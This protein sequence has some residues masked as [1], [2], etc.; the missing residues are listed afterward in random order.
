ME[1]EI[2]A[3]T[4][5]HH[6]SVI[7]SEHPWE[8]PESLKNGFADIV[9]KH[10]NLPTFLMAIECKRMKTDDARQLKW[11]FLVPEG[12]EQ[13]TKR[14]SCFGV[15][16]GFKE[17]QE[18]L[19]WNPYSQWDDVH[20]AKP[21][22]EASYCVLPND[23]QKKRPILE[24][25]S[26]EALDTAEGLAE[27]GKKIAWSQKEEG[28]VRKFIFSAIVTNAKIVACRFKPE[29]ICIE[30]GILD[31]ARV[32]VEEVPFIRFRKSL[33][34]NLPSRRFY[35]LKETQQAR[36]RSVFVATASAIVTLLSGW[37]KGFMDNHI[38]AR[39]IKHDLM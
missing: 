16:G 30:N 10:N 17:D 25:L 38:V 23:E 8:N 26:A 7:S 21:S 14:T 5:K 2:E 11:L 4:S 9:L 34:M 37:D 31:M 15:A 12:K 18:K 13:E 3:T 29:D 22:Y 32:R 39:L 33:Q 35:D 28:R 6:W 24:K 27:E 20:I 36:E 19:Y 1:K